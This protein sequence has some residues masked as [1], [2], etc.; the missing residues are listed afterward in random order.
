VDDADAIEILPGIIPKIIE[1]LK[2]RIPKP[3]IAGG[4]ISDDDDIHKSLHAGAAAVSTIK[5]RL[6][7]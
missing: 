7:L 1:N 6:W 4:L 2:E 5:S 3:I